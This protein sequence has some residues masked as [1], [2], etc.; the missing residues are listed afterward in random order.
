VIGDAWHTAVSLLT[1]ILAAC[2]ALAVF[3]DVVLAAVAVVKFVSE[4]K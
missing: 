2:M 3:V 4:S 1:S